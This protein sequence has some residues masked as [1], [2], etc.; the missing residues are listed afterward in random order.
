[1]SFNLVLIMLTDN[2]HPSV[3][4]GVFKAGAGGD[5]PHR[6]LRQ[7]DALWP[8]RPPKKDSR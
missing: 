4:T 8:Q 2:K 6:T 1:M 3:L 5:F 7:G